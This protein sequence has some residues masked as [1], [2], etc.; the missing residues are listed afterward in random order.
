MTRDDSTRL[1]GYR[2]LRRLGAGRRAE[3]HLGHVGEAAGSGTAGSTV[4]LKLFPAV[5]AGSSAV[6]IAILGSVQAACVPRLHDVATLRD[7][8]ICL[9]LDKLDGPTLSAWLTAE[10]R[11][12]AGELVTVL[13]AVIATAA[14]ARTAGWALGE[15]VP[16]SIRFNGGGRP[17]ITSFSAA[18]PAAEGVRVADALRA[19]F[20]HLGDFIADVL[21]LARH[22]DPGFL[23][24]LRMH[25]KDH[26]MT[27]RLPE[28]EARVFDWAPARPVVLSTVDGAS[29]GAVVPARL[30]PSSGR[31]PALPDDEED[32]VGPT[33]FGITRTIQRARLLLAPRR[34]AGSTQGFLRRHRR[35]AVLA[36]ALIVVGAGTA[37]SL[38]PPAAQG[39]PPPPSSAAAPPAPHSPEASPQQG[40]GASTTAPPDPGS[41]QPA[42]TA[43]DPV[44]AARALLM[45]REIC[46]EQR[47]AGCLGSVDQA[48][49]PLAEADRHAL[50][51]GGQ[52]STLQPSDAITLVGRTGDAAIVLVAG[53]T[54]ETPPA[55][56]LLMKGE[57]GWRLREVFEG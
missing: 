13:G 40:A 43:D 1:A 33:R 46:L 36:G 22:D 28:L 56:L 52:P 8:S 38:V 5:N 55:S 30:A 26:P 20:S 19:E 48:S 37:L 32:E 41:Q 17:V 44:A 45:L 54:A 10:R 50:S 25:E 47:D 23:G 49:S 14:A 57:A 39:T 21:V 29:L 12:Q 2:V 16:S 11:P 34:V 7:G 42:V 31:R 51:E 3:V 53:P 24:W 35:P 9:V 15:L 27:D 6:D 18:S 4:A